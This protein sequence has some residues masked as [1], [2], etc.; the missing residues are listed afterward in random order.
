MTTTLQRIAIINVGLANAGSLTG[1]GDG[2]DA[3]LA[4]SSNTPVGMPSP[5]SQQPSTRDAHTSSSSLPG[6]AGRCRLGRTAVPRTRALG[7]LSAVIAASSAFLLVGCGSSPSPSTPSGR[8]AATPSARSSVSGNGIAALSVEE[9]LAKTRAACAAAGSVHFVGKSAVSDI[10]LVIT[11]KGTSGSAVTSGETVRLI[12][13]GTTAYLKADKAFWATHAPSASG[14]TVGELSADRWV[15]VPTSDAAFADFSQFKSFRWFVDSV[16]TPAGTM[17]KES[18]R[19]INGIPSVGLA[20]SGRPSRSGIL[21]IST[22]GKPYI[23]MIGPGGTAVNTDVFTFGQWGTAIA[24]SA[25]PAEDVVDLTTLSSAS[26]P[27]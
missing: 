10:D 13:A 6:E 4:A 3:T 22:L 2:R 16:L 8:A 23:V 19:K 27:A 11:D 21:Y 7:V 18:V 24:D 17:T 25:P 1:C 14:A 20:D 15:S 26:P 9:L 5:T 12:V